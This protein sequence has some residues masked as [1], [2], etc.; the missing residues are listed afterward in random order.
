MIYTNSIIDGF[1][2]IL[3][4]VPIQIAMLASMLITVRP[5]DLKFE[6]KVMYGMIAFDHIVMIVV[7][8]WYH[9]FGTG[10]HLMAAQLC[11]FAMIYQISLTLLLCSNW[12]F[13]DST[14]IEMT[15]H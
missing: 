2:V 11:I 7:G 1:K 3:G 13:L 14:N 9:F 12:A 6:A 15:E 5:G 4:S 8:L 10:Q